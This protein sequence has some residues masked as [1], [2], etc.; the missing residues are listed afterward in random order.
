MN[1]LVDKLSEG[2]HGNFDIIKASNGKE[3]LG[4]AF[5]EHTDLILLD[6]V[7][8]VMDGMT[9]LQKLRIDPW[10]KSVKVILLTNLSDPG[11]LAKSREHGVKH[12]LIKSDW[13]LDDI[14]KKV[15]EELNLT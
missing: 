14:C 12:Y 5:K 9:F 11:K 7:M 4:V 15:C 8:P 1:V 2:N 10:G 3:G 13:T 6:I